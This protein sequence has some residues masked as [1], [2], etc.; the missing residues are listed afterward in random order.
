MTTTKALKLLASFALAA[1]GGCCSHPIRAF[2]VAPKLICPK[3]EVT[4]AWDVDGEVQ[5]TATPPPPDWQTTAPEKG[6]Q[7]VH[8]EVDTDFALTSVQANPAKEG[9]AQHQFVKV[10]SVGSEL[11]GQS[12][13]C[14]DTRHCKAQITLDAAPGLTVASVSGPHIVRSGKSLADRP[15]CVTPPGGARQCFRG[16][17]VASVNAPASGQWTLEAELLD[18]EE[19]TPPI[20]LEAR[21]TFACK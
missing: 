16:D 21:F 12:A 2:D 15:L 6:E 10:K 14:D 11:R 13:P 5:L 3:Q 17:E 1:I 19:T 7:R 8:P 4:V 9:A 20:K 18:G